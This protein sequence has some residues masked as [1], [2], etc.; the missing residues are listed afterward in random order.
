[1]SSIQEKIRLLKEAQDASNRRP[2]S[3][4]PPPPVLP[5]KLTE[6]SPTKLVS[7]V[8]KKE[9]VTV[10]QTPIPAVEVKS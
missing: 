5:A 9:E 7:V 4:V 1:M 10:Q 2:Q 8:D 3:Y 6:S